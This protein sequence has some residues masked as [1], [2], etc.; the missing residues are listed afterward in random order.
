VIPL[1]ALVVGAL[2]GLVLQPTVPPALAPY[3]PVAVVAA[4]DAVFGGVRAR[5]DGT[6]SERIFLISFVTNSVLAVFLVYLGDQLSVGGQLSEAVVI[7]LG[8]RIFQNLAAV[9][10]I[11]FRA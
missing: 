9:R 6:F 2:L 11:V 8:V 10:R 1:F 3:L 4:L 5:L 7:V